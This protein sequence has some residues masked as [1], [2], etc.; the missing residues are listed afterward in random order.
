MKVKIFFGAM[1]LLSAS[2]IAAQNFQQMPI[3]SGLTADVIANGVGSAL[4]STTIDV[5][6]VSYAFISKDFQATSSSTALTYG[7]PIDRLVNSVVATT[8]GLTY[9]LASYDSN[10][11]LRL[12]SQNDTG[13]IVFSTPT[14]AFKLYMLAT[15]GSG[16]STVTATVNFTDNTSQT[17]TGV[18]VADWYDATGFAIQGFGRIN[19]NTNALESGNATNPRLYQVVLNID[20][21]NQ[22][23]PIQSVTIT[24]TST[25]QGYTNVFAFSA[26]A[27]SDCVPP[28]LNA[29][30]TLTPNSAAISWTS[31]SG[32]TPASYD[33]YYSTTN[34][35]PTS[36]T[37]P[38]FPGI[39]GTS[40][41][42][43][44][45]N[46]NTNYYYW[47]RANCSSGTSQSAWSFFGT[48]KTLCGPMTSLSENFDSYTTGSI[49][50]D[51]W[52]RIID[53]NGSQTI[54][55]ATPVASGTRQIYQ[56]S[57]TTQ[58]PTT[59][60]LPQFSNINAGTNW[61][62]FKARVS[63]A[64]G[65]LNVGYVTDPANSSTFVQLQAVS[66]ANTV[67]ATAG[68]EYTVIIPS[69]VPANARLAIRNTADAK[70][71]Y[72]DDVYWEATPS[73]FAPS[74]L[75]SSNVLANTANIAW[76]APASAPA[77]GYE[78]YYSTS[79][80]AP[81]SA[82]AA[83][84]TST[85]T[86]TTINGLTPATTYYVWIRSA[87]STSD[88]STW[89]GSVTFTT[90]CATLAAPFAQ[91]FDNAAIPN[92]WTNTNPGSTS[93]T[94]LW[95]FTGS[96]DYGANLAN[97]GRPAGTYAWVDASSPYTGAGSNTV[98]LLTPYINLT[99]LTSP[100]ISFD[101]FKNH[102]T[103][104]STTVSPSTYDNNKLTVE[105]NDGSGWVSVWSDT[106]N[107]NLWRTVGVPLASSYI[108][109]TIQV[110][111]TVD[112]NVNG[113]GYFYDDLLL[114]NV[115]VK[116]NPVLATS[117]VSIAKNNIKIYPNPFKDVL[118]IS[119]IEK[120]KSVTISDVSGRV[121]KTIDNPSKEINLSFLNSGLYL[122]TLRLKDGTQFTVKA[123]KN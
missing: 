55:S 32:T 101:W 98:Q 99:G 61:L 67:Y 84:G 13:T 100:Y 111:F 53:T 63:T 82:T 22:A 91:T 37:T 74:G 114:D 68:S 97:N 14:P 116:Q 83:L 20:A 50:P 66:I 43:P 19:R 4:A 96:A 54:S 58:N 28:T 48:F 92:C 51:C 17:I 89:F 104:T 72:W 30:G 3:S 56:Y 112:K 115:E 108:G 80:T 12:A 57:S 87:C 44:S 11:S 8:P 107:S 45:L 64:T 38:N 59:V 47:V 122:V 5:D 113:N 35:A 110:R 65:T 118:N 46:P 81:T 94:L 123:I 24:K 102:S 86:S 18:T 78:Y 1:A 75:T 73:C 121:V 26:D 93:A 33:V 25:A 2:S 27:Y 52:A 49:V 60:V 41:T 42:I 23:K 6:G 21:A 106:S 79:S 62:R 7:L 88:K 105:V 29:V 9:K 109:A 15:S 40:T 10:N 71:Y 39:T 119:E 69:S 120:V 77:N 95:K 70:S 85:A 76:T 34:T 16:A 103:S 31:P 36:S 117:D 90:A